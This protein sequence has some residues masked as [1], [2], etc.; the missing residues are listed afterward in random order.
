MVEQLVVSK[1]PEI[2]IPDGADALYGDNPFPVTVGEGEMYFVPENCPLSSEV[3]AAT[4][5]ALLGE[6]NKRVGTLIGSNEGI[7]KRLVNEGMATCNVPDRYS[8]PHLGFTERFC[9]ITRKIAPFDNLTPRMVEV[10]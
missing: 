10:L 8:L 2:V 5:L 9:R 7:G 4:F 6:P 3:Q 1:N